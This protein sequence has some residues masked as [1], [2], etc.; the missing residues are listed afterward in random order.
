MLGSQTTI[1]DIGRPLIDVEFCVVDLETTGGSA[2]KGSMITE[3]GAVKVRGGQVTG[4]FQT[5]VDPEGPIPAYISVLTGITDQMVISAPRIAEVLPSFLEFARGTTLVAHNAPFDIGFLKHFA[6]ELDHPWPGFDV[7]D[8]VKLARR[9]LMRDE[10]PN[11]KLATLAAKFGATTI[12]NHR[13]LSDARATADVLHALFERLGSFGVSTLEELPSFTNRVTPAQ[14]AKRHLADTVPDAPGVYLFRGPRDEVLYVGTS[15]RLRRRVQSYFTGA[16]SRSRM[17][18]MVTVA[19]AVDTVVCATPLEAAVRE[20]RLIGAHAPPYNRRSR[21]QDSVA[22]LKLT[23][24]PWPRLSIVRK[25]ADDDADYIGPFGGRSVAEAALLALHDV[26]AIRQCTTRL[27]RRPRGTPCVLADMGRCLAPC[28]GRE[29]ADDYAQEVERLRTDLRE[30]ASHTVA[31][32]ETKMATLAAEEE[33]E[34][35]ATQRD[36]LRAVVRGVARTQRLRSITGEPQIVAARP[37]DAGWEVH[38]I[39]HG[40]LAAAG[41]LTAGIDARAWTTELVAGA[42]TVTPAHGPAPAATVA[43]TELVATWLE[44]PDL[45]MVDGAWQVPIRSATRHLARYPE[46][47]RTSR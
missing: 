34:Q 41:L 31:A 35:A 46:T 47:S 24:E 44:E 18:E 3:V 42:E 1:D 10:V 15:R 11:C 17:R 4:E 26:F 37:V 5:L 28:D 6:R 12:P 33:Y 21:R 30:D 19:T 45:R 36:R 9:V 20:L 43:E 2:A 39:R 32:L 27:P 40:R 7:V 16:E 29:I 25:V 13:A 22:W 23:V 8:T 38:V 14:R